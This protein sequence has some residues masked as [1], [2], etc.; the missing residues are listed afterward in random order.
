LHRF[1]SAYFARADWERRNGLE[2]RAAALLPALALAR[3]DGKSP[4]EYL[5][6]E[7]RVSLRAAARAAVIAEA[8]LLS[9]AV[10]T[11]LAG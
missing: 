2:A 1:A 9:D 6:E 8:T 10:D 5:H 7:Q 4:L 3:V 11:L